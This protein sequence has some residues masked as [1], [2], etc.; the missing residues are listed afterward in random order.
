M[1]EKRLPL[2]KQKGTR[3]ADGCAN[4][5]G[6]SEKSQKRSTK[7]EHQVHSRGE[8]VSDWVIKKGL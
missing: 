3:S 5:R 6:A 1:S 4:L 8:S 7:T 2:S